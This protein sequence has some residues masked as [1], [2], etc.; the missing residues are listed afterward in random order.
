MRHLFIP[1]IT[2]GL[3]YDFTG[4]GVQFMQGIRVQLGDISPTWLPFNAGDRGWL[5][6]DLAAIDREVVSDSYFIF[7]SI[8][9]L[10]PRESGV[11]RLNPVG[12]PRLEHFNPLEVARICFTKSHAAWCEPHRRSLRP[13]CIYRRQ[14]AEG[15]GAIMSWRA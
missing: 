5:G 3:K 8:L 9:G 11:V 10:S 13:A 1:F 2:S 4:T 7:A 15:C 6:A 14:K 12:V